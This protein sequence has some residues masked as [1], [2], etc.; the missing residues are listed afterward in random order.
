VTRPPQVAT[1]AHLRSSRKRTVQVGAVVIVITTLAMSA[2]LAGKAWTSSARAASATSVK[3]A[4]STF[5]QFR[6][7]ENAIRRQS[8]PRA[9]LIVRESDELWRQRLAELATPWFQV[10]ANPKVATHTLYV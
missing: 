2:I 10:V 4:A 9:R 1:Q 6:C 8:P 5:D 7:I 3:A